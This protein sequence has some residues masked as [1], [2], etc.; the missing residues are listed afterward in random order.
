MMAE[1]IN[2][3]LVQNIILYPYIMQQYS[4][5]VVITIIYASSDVYP[6]PIRHRYCSTRFNTFLSALKR[7]HRGGA[8]FNQK[9]LTFYFIY[10]IAET[11]KFARNLFIGAVKDENNAEKPTYMWVKPPTPKL[12]PS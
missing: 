5:N 7:L 4:I 9:T 12:L 2:H 6:H 8:T 3:E 11:Y 1:D 10:H